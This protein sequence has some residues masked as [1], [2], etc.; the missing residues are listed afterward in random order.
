M[1]WTMIDHVTTVQIL[2]VLALSAVLVTR[3]LVSASSAA[4][5]PPL[6]PGP[7]PLPLIGNA[8]DLPTDRPWKVYDN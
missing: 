3:W 1:S 8:L 5:C 7:K 4:T 6:P 2:S